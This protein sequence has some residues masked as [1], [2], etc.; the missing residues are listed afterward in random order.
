MPT[1]LQA[2]VERRSLPEPTDV[3]KEHRPFCA[4]QLATMHRCCK[5][6]AEAA[7]VALHVRH[8]PDPTTEHEAGNVWILPEKPTGC[9]VAVPEP[10]EPTSEPGRAAHIQNASRIHP[11]DS[12]NRLGS[13]NYVDAW[14]GRKGIPLSIKGRDACRRM[15]ANSHVFRAPRLV[16]SWRRRSFAR[17]QLD[18]SAWRG[19]L[20]LGRSA[21]HP[22]LPAE[23]PSEPASALIPAQA[24][25]VR[26]F[27]RGSA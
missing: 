1:L 8:R 6:K 19:I 9:V 18:R 23:G 12:A 20:G 21:Q 3:G 22:Q 26:A 24:V 4:C 25:R 11:T 27:I 2:Q 17:H 13:T 10:P 5:R 16:E 14:C 15:P 7:E